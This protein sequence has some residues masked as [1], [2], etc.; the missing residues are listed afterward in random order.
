MTA[1]IKPILPYLLLAGI[2]LALILLFKPTFLTHWDSYLYTTGAL[3]F[4]PI[5]LAGGRWFFSAIY[6]SAWQVL[7]PLVA[8]DPTRAWQLFSGL[9]MA[10]SVLNVLLL[11][12]LAGR[13]ASHRS[14][15]LAAIIWA[16]SPLVL[17][18]CSTVMTEPLAVT[19]ILLVLLALP[20]FQT[21]AI[22]IG[23]FIFFSGIAGVL[24]GLA[25]NIREPLVFYL[26]ATLGLIGA[27]PSRL[28]RRTGII[29]L[30]A[31]LT[32]T[33]ACAAVLGA[34]LKLAAVFAGSSWQQIQQSWQA[35]MLQ[36]RAQMGAD[37]PRMLLRNCCYLMVYLVMAS[38]VI[39]LALPMA[40][41]AGRYKTS[42]LKILLVGTALYC[43][44]QIANHSLIFNPR[45]AIFAA[46]IL[47][48]PTAS[49][50]TARWPRALGDKLL[51]AAVIV[52]HLACIAGGWS[53]VQNYHLN[54][55]I[56]ARQLDAAIGQ[57]PD[58]CTIVAGNFSS[59]IQYH[60][61]LHDRTGW[62]IVYSGWSWPRG[63]LADTLCQA[64]DDGREV[65]IATLPA[66]WLTMLRDYERQ[67]VQDLKTKFTFEPGPPFMARLSLS[68]PPP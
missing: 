26:P 56:Q 4:E 49:A 33:V 52:F 54:R 15:L 23:R 40:I 11:Y 41:R 3:R 55:A 51:P 48:I 32:F 7:K 62:Q 47:I 57:L 1:R 6:G 18:Y 30:L 8:N 17:I 13:L 2:H 63:Q 28:G 20:D 31:C 29:K 67:E 19:L 24:M 46:L 10:L 66:A 27:F 68:Q 39:V 53:T 9:S 50:L 37:L 22:P 60:A 5:P 34:G 59:L 42:A 65:Y 25:V 35:G 43:L 36:E 61:K 44:A 14:A 21:P 16:T 64:L 58:N 12:R 45:F 38:P